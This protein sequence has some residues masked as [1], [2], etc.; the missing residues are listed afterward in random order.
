M[1]IKHDH[2]RHEFV[3]RKMKTEQIALLSTEPEA[4]IKAIVNRKESA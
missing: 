4:L 3:Q 2:I 1:C